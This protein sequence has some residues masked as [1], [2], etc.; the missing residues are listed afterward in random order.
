MTSTGVCSRWKRRYSP[1]GWR[2]GVL[3]RSYVMH[4]PHRK[5]EARRAWE[6]SFEAFHDGKHSERR[7]EMDHQYKRFLEWLDAK[8]GSDKETEGKQERTRL[9]KKKSSGHGSGSN[10][11]SRHTKTAPVENA[12]ARASAPP[13]GEQQDPP[14]AG[15][16]P[17][18][19]PQRR[20]TTK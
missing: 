10:S 20:R 14:P 13:R 2:F 3:P 8:Y 9:C 18:P 7:R 12:T 11:T 19:V 4:Y 16:S 15:R 6:G 17:A 1:S 5:S